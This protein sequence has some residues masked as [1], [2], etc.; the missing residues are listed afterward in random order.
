MIMGPI[1]V[2]LATVSLRLFLHHGVWDVFPAFGV[3]LVV[4]ALV[5]IF[6]SANAARQAPEGRRFIWFIGSLVGQVLLAIVLL[7]TIWWLLPVSFS[8]P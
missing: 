8:G 6:T 1:A 4:A 5:A 3:A 2:A 7:N